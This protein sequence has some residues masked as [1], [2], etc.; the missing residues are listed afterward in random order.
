MHVVSVRV[1]SAREIQIGSRTEMSGIIKEPV[2]RAVVMADGVEGDAIVSTEHH[3]GLDQALYL[4][5]AD[6]YAWWGMPEGLFGENLTLSTLGSDDP[7]VGDRYVIGEVVLEV[8]APRIPCAKVGVRAGDAEFP[9]RFTAA[10]RP[11]PYARVISGGEIEPGTEVELRRAPDD[12]LTILEIQ[13]LYHDR[14]PAIADLERA[15]AA[16]VARRVREG[17]ER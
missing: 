7:R 12:A 5:G 17:M 13:D 8:T 16:P 9:K 11:G 4:Y 15:L 3:G 10:R 14:S 6:D 2:Q 1:G